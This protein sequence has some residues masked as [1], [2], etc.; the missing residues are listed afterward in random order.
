MTTLLNRFQGQL[1]AILLL[2]TLCAVLN[3]ICVWDFHPRM[4]G[5]YDDNLAYYARRAVVQ[6]HYPGDLYH[7]KLQREWVLLSSPFWISAFLFSEFGIDPLHSSVFFTVIKPWLILF[8]VYLLSYSVT[9]RPYVS[10]LTA[11]LVISGRVIEQNLALYGLLLY[12]PYQSDLAYALVLFVIALLIKNRIISAMACQLVLGTLHPTLALSCYLFVLTAV[13]ACYRDYTRCQILFVLF[14]AIP[15]M[16]IIAAPTL[17]ITQ[18]INRDNLGTSRDIY[19]ALDDNFHGL[20]WDAVTWKQQFLASCA[21]LLYLIPAMVSKTYSWTRPIKILALVTLVSVVLTV[22]GLLAKLLC[23]W[24]YDSSWLDI[25]IRFHQMLLPRMS[26]FTLI[27]SLVLVVDYL[28]TVSASGSA[29]TQFAAWMALLL[30]LCGSISPGIASGTTIPLYLSLLLAVILTVSSFAPHASPE[31]GGRRLEIFLSAFSWILLLAFFV[32]IAA[33]FPIPFASKKEFVIRLFPG[34]LVAAFVLGKRE[35]LMPANSWLLLVGGF[36]VLTVSYPIHITSRR[37][38]AIR[39]ASGGLIAAIMWGGAILGV[40]RRSAF[41]MAE[42]KEA[43]IRNAVVK[44][45]PGVVAIFLIVLCSLLTIRW[46]KPTYLMAVLILSL[47]AIPFVVLLWR[48]QY[49]WAVPV[50]FA[51]ASMIEVSSALDKNILPAEH[52][53]RSWYETTQWVKENTPKETSF[54]M[55]VDHAKMPWGWCGWRTYA[56]RGFVPLFEPMWA[57]VY[58]PDLRYVAFAQE[59]RK[60][61][62]A[63]YPAKTVQEY[64]RGLDEVDLAALRDVTGARY[65]IT[66][67]SR[68]LPAPCIFYSKD[69]AIYDLID[70]PKHDQ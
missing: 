25:A 40:I 44:A 5:R 69:Y 46:S 45:F 52:Q 48:Q 64:Y 58:F 60:H 20:L 15:L 59:T 13:F 35:I 16:L 4:A 70:L 42:G 56:E 65:A 10:A 54:M 51:L 34:L 49:K 27:F 12:E 53:A 30:L 37:E 17:V 63:R 31:A 6:D 55:L 32:V 24:L 39:L 9:H 1:P 21:I 57:L 11:I 2:G 26:A 19:D 66:A 29:V 47:F 8:S 43:T 62:E 36:V 22:V 18:V 3:V 38:F 50:L 41:T 33:Y 14:S 61:F 68:P 28:A 7:N 23:I 67:T